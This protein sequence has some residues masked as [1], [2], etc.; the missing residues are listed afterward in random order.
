MSHYIEEFVR[1]KFNDHKINIPV[2]VIHHPTSFNATLFNVDEFANH[3]EFKLVQLGQQFRYYSTIFTLKNIRHKLIWMPG[4]RNYDK[5]INMMI[6]EVNER[7]IFDEK[8]TMDNYKKY[9]NDV[10]VTYIEN[11]NEYDLFM[12]NAIL[13]IHLKD[14]SANNAIVECIVRNQPFIVN[15]HPAVVEY[16]GENYPLYMNDGFNNDINELTTLEKI[17]EGHEYLKNMNKSHLNIN[18]FIVDLIRCTY[19]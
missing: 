1:R 13:L 3:N 6:E 5:Y 12:K 17:K 15:K 11:Y 2:H 4:S 14:A 8:I 16:V 19:N 9:L 7:K 10:E 18:K